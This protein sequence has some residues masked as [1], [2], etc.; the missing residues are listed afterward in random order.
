MVVLNLYK[1]AMIAIL[2]G[3][4]INQSYCQEIDF[5]SERRGRISLVDGTTVNF[6]RINISS[7]SATCTFKGGTQITYPVQKIYSLQLR[8]TLV[9]EMTLGFT[10]LGLTIGL[11][12]AYAFNNTAAEEYKGSF[13]AIYTSMFAVGGFI[14]GLT[15]PKYKT[16]YVKENFA[17]QWQP[18]I[19]Y[20]THNNRIYPGLSFAINIRK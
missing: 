2:L 7:D 6:S 17:I 8:K 15:L 4:I 3:C 18:E 20:S 16:V 11:L 5:P 14:L 19:I 10:G 9:V 1:T 13:I 12:S